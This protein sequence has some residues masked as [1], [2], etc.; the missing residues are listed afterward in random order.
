MPRAHVRRIAEAQRI[1][2]GDRPRAHGEDV[3]QDAA[4]T[5]RGAL[6]GLDGAR[7]VVAL[8][9]EGDRQAV[10][11]RDD[12]SV[13]AWPRDHAL[14]GRGQGLEQGLAALVRAVLA[15]H[16]AEHRQLEVV[17]LAAAEALADSHEL[18]VGDAQAAV[19]R[20][21]RAL[22]EGHR[23]GSVDQDGDVVGLPRDVLE[24]DR[25]L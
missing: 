12:T 3:A 19:Q 2:H 6:V 22:G 18:V 1:E 15:P 24:L 4:Y 20:F 8:D 10:P 14:A 11:D 9:L 21:Y 23:C 25:G 5:S 16:H 17:G 7:M 13:L